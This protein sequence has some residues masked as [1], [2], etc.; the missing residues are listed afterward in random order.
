M[1]DGYELDEQDERM[2]AAN[3][4]WVKCTVQMPTEPSDGELAHPGTGS[5]THVIYFTKAFPDMANGRMETRIE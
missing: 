4:L 1:D 3:Q 5:D 2:G